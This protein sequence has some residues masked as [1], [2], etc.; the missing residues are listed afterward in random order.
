MKLETNT[1]FLFLFIYFF[2]LYKNERRIGLQYGHNNYSI[3]NYYFQKNKKPININEVDTEKI[4]F[5]NKTQYG[6]EG[7]NKYYIG[8]VGSTGFRP[9]HMI[10]VYTNRI[11]V[12]ADNKELLK[13]IKMWDKTVDLFNKKHNKR[14]LYNNTI[15]N[16][17]IKTKISPYIEKFHGN[18]KLTKDK[19]YGNSIL[20]IES[21]CEVKNKYYPQTFLDEFFEI[22]N[23]NNIN[24]LFKELE[25]I[26][27]W[28]DY[29]SNN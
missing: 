1:I 17:H 8:Y 19:Y 24:S 28:S 5:S 10:I 9:L 29:E 14:V 11:N 12:L 7:A 22:H 4:V 21:I 25:H 26:F 27:D 18:K 20:L 3:V 13:N 15:Y 6:K 23:D 2:S 16:E